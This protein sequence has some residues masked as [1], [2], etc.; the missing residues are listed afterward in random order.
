MYCVMHCDQRLSSIAI[1]VS[2]RFQSRSLIFSPMVS[3]LH[4]ILP[5]D[6][7]YFV[8]ADHVYFVGDCIESKPHWNL[9]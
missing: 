8:N 4:D 3:R 1:D 5:E 7:L 2:L 9:S 6:V